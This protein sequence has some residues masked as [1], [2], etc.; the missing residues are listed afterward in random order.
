MKVNY[1]LYG[2]DHTSRHLASIVFSENRSEHFAYM[3]PIWS[4]A[5]KISESTARF[6][7]ILTQGIP[8]YQ[9]GM[10]PMSGSTVQN[11]NMNMNMN[12]I[13]IQF[14]IVSKEVVESFVSCGGRSCD[15]LDMFSPLWIF[16][17]LMVALIWFISSVFVNF[18]HNDEIDMFFPPVWVFLYWMNIT[19]VALI[20]FISNVSVNFYFSVNEMFKFK[21]RVSINFRFF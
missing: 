20:W 8:T 12:K 3:V 5:A 2:A 14:S 11:M 16:W 17:C 6:Q 18:C 9:S 15:H 4:L 7:L 1:E 21:R 13:Q 10:V 19:N